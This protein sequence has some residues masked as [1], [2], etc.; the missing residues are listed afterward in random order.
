MNSDKGEKTCPLCA[1]EMDLTD[2][3]FNPCQCGYQ[4]PYNQPLPLSLF[5]SLVTLFEHYRESL[6]ESL[7]FYVSS[8]VVLRI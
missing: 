3:H 2:Q 1:E 8:V 6:K 4:V 7:S 5:L